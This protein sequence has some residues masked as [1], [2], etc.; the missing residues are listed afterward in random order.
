[1]F[2]VQPTRTKML[3]KL[4]SNAVCTTIKTFALLS[5]VHSHS[6]GASC[7]LIGLTPN[8]RIALPV[9]SP[10]DLHVNPQK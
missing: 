10:R 9:S 4:R 2:C 6:F 1:M 8:L 3:L 7:P 5:R